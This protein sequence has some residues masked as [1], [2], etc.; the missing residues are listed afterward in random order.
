MVHFQTFFYGLSDIGLVRKTN[1][2]LWASLPEYRSFILADGMGGHRCGDVAAREAVSSLLYAFSTLGSE[3]QYFEDYQSAMLFMRASIVEAN[4]NVYALGQRHPH[5]RGMGTTLCCV[6]VHHQHIV[7]AH[8]GDSRL[9]SFRD[10]KL[11]RL[12]QDHSLCNKLSQENK[13]AQ[14]DFSQYRHI[15][16][17]AIGV[18]AHVAPDIAARRLIDGDVYFMCSDGLSDYIPHETMQNI[19]ASSSDLEEAAQR[20]IS[21]AKKEGGRD[22]ITIVMMK[23]EQIYEQAYLPR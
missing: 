3:L 5:L 14:V 20:L 11:K 4:R 7:Y 15:L 12:T 17:Q 21:A 6:Y 10:G 2:D 13:D 9:Y 8:V 18:Q 19:I 23:M 16:T 22:N 1:Q